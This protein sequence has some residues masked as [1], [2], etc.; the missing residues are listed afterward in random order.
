MNIFAY[1]W[2][3]DGWMI[4]LREGGGLSERSI[5]AANTNSMAYIGELRASLKA[6]QE[7]KQLAS[8]LLSGND[9]ALLSEFVSD[10]TKHAPAQLHELDNPPDGVTRITVNLEATPWLKSGWIFAL[11]SHGGYHL[12][13]V[14]AVSEDGSGYAHSLLIGI[15]TL[16]NREDTATILL[17]HSD[18]LLAAGNLTKAD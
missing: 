8:I 4:A 12:A 13:H 16:A 7:D 9:Y 5:N 14:S 6:W 1:D 2:L 18:Y 11:R 10:V 3:E 17:S 15:K